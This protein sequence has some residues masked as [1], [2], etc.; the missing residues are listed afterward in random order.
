MDVPASVLLAMRP[1]K[2][3][4]GEQGDSFD[5]NEMPELGKCVL[6]DDEN[7]DEDEEEEAEAT[8]FTAEV[9]ANFFREVF[10]K[11]DLDINQWPVCQVS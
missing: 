7:D 4:V 9:H 3:I 6:D 1:M 2:R 10:K 5:D 8:N 11:Y